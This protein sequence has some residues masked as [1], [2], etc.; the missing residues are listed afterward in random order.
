MPKTND[1]T[2]GPWTTRQA[3]YTDAHRRE[4]ED[5]IIESTVA[6]TDIPDLAYTPSIA[7]MAREA[8]AYV[9]A[10]APEMLEALEALQ[11]AF[12]NG[13]LAFTHKRQADSE[14]YHRANALMSAALAKA[15]SPVLAVNG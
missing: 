2:P 7:H 9:I 14:P 13:E 6:N 3:Y 10:A 11:Q 1:I 12:V 5:W 8:D 15:C 4:G